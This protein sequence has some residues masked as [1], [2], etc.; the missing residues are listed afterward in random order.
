M[1]V[2]FIPGVTGSLYNQFA[3][4]VAISFGISA[5]NSLTLT[6]ALSAAFLRHRGET[7]FPPFRW[8]NQ[9]FDWLAHNYAQG[10]RKLVQWHWAVASHC[11][12]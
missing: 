4:T 1:P 9:G 2:A 5:F 3:L 7:K 12:S 11:S 10:V 8:F 6:P